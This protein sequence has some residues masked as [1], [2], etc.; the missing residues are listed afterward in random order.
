[1]SA[2]CQNRTLQSSPHQTS[3]AVLYIQA[4]AAR[5]EQAPTLVEND[6]SVDGPGVS[7]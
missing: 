4:I 5:M 3:G 1:M 6:N 2:L 7:L